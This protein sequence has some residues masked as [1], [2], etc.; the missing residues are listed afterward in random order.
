ME[1]KTNKKNKR[2]VYDVTPEMHKKIR[3]KVSS[4]GTTVANLLNDF[5]D[6]LLF[7]RKTK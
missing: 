3:M 5:F 1:K 2:I 6:K 4:M 7:E